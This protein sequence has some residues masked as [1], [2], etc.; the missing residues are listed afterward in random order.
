MK[1]LLPIAAATLLASCG[2]PM[3][4]A[5]YQNTY[6]G[7]RQL[8]PDLKEVYRNGQTPAQIRASIR[9]SSMKDMLAEGTMERPAEGWPAGSLEA[10]HEQANGAQ[11]AKIERFTFGTVKGDT[12]EGVFYH[13]VFYDKNGRSFGWFVTRD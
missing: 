9:R 3:N 5:S 8:Y 13:R 1:I 12:A 11:V 2:V 4:S 6:A 10:F 7:Q